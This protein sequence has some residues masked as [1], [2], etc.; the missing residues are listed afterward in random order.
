MGES[1]VQYLLLDFIQWDT[2]DAQPLKRT[3]RERDRGGDLPSWTDAG[4]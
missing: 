4:T 1:M 3:L 2:H